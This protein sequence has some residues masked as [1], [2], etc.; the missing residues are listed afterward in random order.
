MSEWLREVGREA[1]RT[2]FV[3]RLAGDVYSIFASTVHDDLLSA[4]VIDLYHVSLLTAFLC[5][6]LAEEELI[7]LGTRGVLALSCMAFLSVCIAKYSLALVRS[8]RS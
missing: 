2:H 1:G 4:F 6:N 3:V 5:R 8:T 7:E